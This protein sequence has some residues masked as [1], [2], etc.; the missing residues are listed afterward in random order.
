MVS[1]SRGNATVALSLF[2]ILKNSNNKKY[3]I[4]LEVKN[5]V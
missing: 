5:D 3:I 2:Y 1:K 4:I